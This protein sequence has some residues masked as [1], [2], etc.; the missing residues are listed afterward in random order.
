MRSLYGV[1]DV[2]SC[3]ELKQELVSPGYRFADEE[4][5]KQFQNIIQLIHFV[6]NGCN[7]ESLDVFR[8]LEL[9]EMK[10]AGDLERVS[11]LLTSVVDTANQ[12]LRENSPALMSEFEVG[13]YHH[14]DP[15]R[16]SAQII[17]DAIPGKERHFSQVVKNLPD[18]CE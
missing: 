6:I 17:L 12:S 4:S 3:D 9:D 8:S 1:V 7:Q 16:K 13:F 15:N 10:S 11:I 2:K 18:I 14:L 5:E